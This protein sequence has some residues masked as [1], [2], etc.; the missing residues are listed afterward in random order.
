MF[1]QMAFPFGVEIPVLSGRAMNAML[2]IVL[3]RTAEGCS[4]SASL[5]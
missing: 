4:A 5:K 1:E 3:Q 2:H